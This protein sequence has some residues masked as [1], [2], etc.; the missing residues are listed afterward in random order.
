VGT[1]RRLL[2][3]NAVRAVPF[4]ILRRADPLAALASQDADEPRYCVLRQP[5]DVDDLGQRFA[6]GALIIAIASAILLVRSLASP[7]FRG[8]FP[9]LALLLTF[10]EY[11]DIRKTKCWHARSLQL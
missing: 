2:L 8:G 10:A 9:F 6:R 4:Y 3:R 5:R 11:S 1:N 7:A